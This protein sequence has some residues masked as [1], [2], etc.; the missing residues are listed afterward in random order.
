MRSLQEI[1]TAFNYLSGIP[2]KSIPPQERTPF[3][4]ALA[5]SK[6]IFSQEFLDACEWLVGE[7]ERKT[8]DERDAV[9][10][11]DDK[12]RAS[13]TG[14]RAEVDRLNGIRDGLWS[15]YTEKVREL[16]AAYKTA[17][18]CEH[19]LKIQAETIAKLVAESTAQ[20]QEIERLKQQLR[21]SSNAQ[22]PSPYAPF[23][24]MI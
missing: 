19:R 11:S 17:S 8:N 3:L 18:S 14:W 4:I 1:T 7:L 10:Q 5:G 22:F 2:I 13:T 9:R 6:G 24:P 23:A 16:D 15:S 20:Q 21:G 12:V